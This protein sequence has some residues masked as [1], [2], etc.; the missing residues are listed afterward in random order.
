[1][2]IFGAW[3]GFCHGTQNPNPFAESSPAPDATFG[4]CKCLNNIKILESNKI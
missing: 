2:T 1:M 3:L 4:V